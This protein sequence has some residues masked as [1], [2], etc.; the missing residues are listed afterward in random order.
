MADQK[1]KT[2]HPEQEHENKPLRVGLFQIAKTSDPVLGQVVEAMRRD[3][4]SKKGKK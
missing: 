3:Q 1:K 2:K 4:N